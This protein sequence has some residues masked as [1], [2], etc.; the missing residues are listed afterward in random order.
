MTTPTSSLNRSGTRSSEARMS[1]PTR[2]ANAI[3]RIVTIRP[4]SER[5]CNARTRR[6][7]HSFRMVSKKSFRALPSST[8]GHSPSTPSKTCEIALPPSRALSFSVSRSICVSP[9]R[10][11]GVMTR[12][13]SVTGPNALIFSVTGDVTDCESSAVIHEVCI[14]RLS[15]PTGIAIPKS[16]QSSIPTARTASCS[17]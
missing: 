10:N 11:S 5:S 13:A 2:P 6:L 7:L 9:P 1:T 4:P 8:S 3:S 17:A 16:G 15:F 14:E 12:R